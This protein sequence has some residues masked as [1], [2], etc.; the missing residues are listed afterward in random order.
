MSGTGNGIGKVIFPSI[1]SIML[2]SCDQNRQIG[3]KQLID[4]KDI[5]SRVWHEKNI[6]LKSLTDYFDKSN[7]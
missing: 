3:E 1:S 6:F 4:W 2:N 7:L 5:G